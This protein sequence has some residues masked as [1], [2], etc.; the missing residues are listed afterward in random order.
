MG[1]GYKLFTILRNWTRAKWNGGS[2]LEVMGAGLDG[3]ANDLYYVLA[4]TDPRF[5]RVSVNTL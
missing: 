4:K 3:G 5:W 1:G 2:E